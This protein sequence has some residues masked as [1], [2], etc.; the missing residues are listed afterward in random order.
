[1][2]SLSLQSSGHPKVFQ[3]LPV[4]SSRA[5]Y[6]SFNLPKDSSPGFWSTA[7][8]EIAQLGLA[9]A[10]APPHRLSPPDAM[11]RGLIMQKACRNPEGP[12]HLVG[13]RFQVCFTPLKGVLFTFPSRY[14]FAIGHRL[15]FS[16]GGWAHRIRTGF[17]VS[18]PNWDT[19]RASVGF[20]Y[21]AFTPSGRVFQR[22]PLPTSR[23]TARSR[24]PR[25]QAP[26]FGLLRVRSPLLAQSL[27]FSFPP[28]TEMFHFPGCRPAGL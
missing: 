11:T 2:I 27:L 15:V 19:A 4:R 10:L 24:N 6:R 3:H 26:W 14:W 23:P 18:R 17:H 1:M 20:G 5:C 7:S 16:L 13:T 25:E 21:G 12:R 22:V 28:G 9:F 8:D